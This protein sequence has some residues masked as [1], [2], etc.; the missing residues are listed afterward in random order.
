MWQLPTKI[1]EDTKK[2][3]S[4][5]YYHNKELFNCKLLCKWYCKQQIRAVTKRAGIDKL[6]HTVG[7]GKL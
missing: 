3:K 2:S 1:F 4:I 5:S 6:G 7:T